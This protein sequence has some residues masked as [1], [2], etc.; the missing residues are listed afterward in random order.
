MNQLIMNLIEQGNY[1]QVRDEIIKINVVDI[2]QILEEVKSEQMLIVFRLLPKEI[3]ADVFSYM[4]SEQQ[5]HIIEV[6]T[7]K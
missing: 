2:A 5:L 7:D 3:A 6:I 4:S 1:S